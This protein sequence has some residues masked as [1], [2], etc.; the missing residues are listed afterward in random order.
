ME[1]N[2]KKDLEEYC[3][4]LLEINNKSEIFDKLDIGI[5]I[6]DIKNTDLINYLTESKLNKLK[7]IYQ[8]N[9]NFYIIGSFLTDILLSSIEYIYLRNPIQFNK[10]N[11]IQSIL[12]NEVK[13]RI[14]FDGNTIYFTIK[15]Y[16]LYKNNQIIKYSLME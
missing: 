8:E 12:Q 13:E 7:K 6:Y 10:L 4:R 11:I 14:L 1:D 15:W 16:N 2:K 5:F 9:G 3:G